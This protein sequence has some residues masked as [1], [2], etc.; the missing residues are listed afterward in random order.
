M[1]DLLLSLLIVLAALVAVAL[2]LRWAASGSLREGAKSYPKR[3]SGIP[4]SGGYVPSR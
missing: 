2:A 1:P 4:R 3:A